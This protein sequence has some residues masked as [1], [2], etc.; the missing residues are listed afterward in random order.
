MIHFWNGNKSHARQVYEHQL[1]EL[2]V[3]Q[4]GISLE[5][6]NDKTDYPLADDEGSVL[7]RGADLLVTVAGNR[8]FA[9][10]AYIEIPIALCQGLLGLR[11]A[12]IRQ[13]R[14]SEFELMT[15]ETLKKQSVGV[16]DTWVDAELFR[17]NGYRVDERGSLEEMLQ[18]LEEGAVDYLTLGV[19]EAADILALHQ[20]GGHSL[21]IEE[22]KLLR[23]PLPLVFYVS[24]SQP[25]LAEKLTQGLMTILDN[26]TFDA[27]FKQHFGAA[28]QSVGVESR[29]CIEL[30]NPFLPHH[31][32]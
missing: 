20:N 11:V 7:E 14:Q 21:V 29:H 24:E 26:G 18:W 4:A 2:V 15:Q 27:L 5:I 19:T 12:I 17:Y 3:R 1:L 30:I 8:K 25:E 6:E 32:E 22:T 28:L 23:Y 31:F 9:S 16:P 10:K 13:P